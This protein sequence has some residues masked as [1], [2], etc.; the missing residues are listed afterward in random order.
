MYQFYFLAV[1]TNILA[2][3]ALAGNSTNQKLGLS[4]IFNRELFEQTGFRIGLGILAFVVGIF[5]LLTVAP[6][7][8][9]VVGDI[10]PAVSGLILGTIL[11]LEYYK[12]RSDVTSPFVETLQR[13]FGN[14]S[15]IFGTGGIVVGVLHFLFPRLLLL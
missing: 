11:T 9:P 7:D 3:A 15:S 13:L 5:K 8:V 6:E 12:E 2:G 4:S 1:A 14:N 10:V